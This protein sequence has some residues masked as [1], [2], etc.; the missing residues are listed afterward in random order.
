MTGEAQSTLEA[1]GI[2]WPAFRNHIPCMAHVIQ[3]ALGAFMSSLCVTSRTKSWEA[4]ERDQQFGENASIDIRKSHRLQTEGNA[5]IN[6]MLAMRPGLAKIIEKECISR[7]V[8]HPETDY[9]IAESAW[10][11][12]YADTWSSKRVHLLPNSPCTN[13][14]TTNYGCENM[15]EF[16]TGVAWVSVQITRHRP[17]VAPE[18]HN[19]LL[20]ATLHYSGQIDHC[21]AGDGSFE[22]IPILDP[23]D[24]E[25]AYGHITSCYRSLQWHVQSHGWRY[26]SCR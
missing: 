20:L 13:L 12:D 9:H 26:A 17:W 1:S 14:S 7:Y 5:R 2:E 18:S 19:Q 3:L 4:H 15:V 16:D 6:K 25:E 23:V 11:I 10:G 8:E 21:Q 22:A 24:V